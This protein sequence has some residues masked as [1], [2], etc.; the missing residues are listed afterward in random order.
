MHK[1][2]II[3]TVMNAALLFL[4]ISC[5]SGEDPGEKGVIEEATDKIA[6]EATAMIKKPLSEAK[7]VAEI[8]NE[9]T[10]QIEDVKKQE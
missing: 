8:A 7:A 9:R 2:K 6:E 10:R 5:S 4:T 3:F 1:P